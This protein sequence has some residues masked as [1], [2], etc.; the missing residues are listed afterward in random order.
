MKKILKIY[1]SIILFLFIFLVLLILANVILKINIDRSKIQKQ[2]S[3]LQQISEQNAMEDRFLNFK[4]TL[5]SMDIVLDNIIV[6]DK[7]IDFQVNKDMNQQQMINLINVFETTNYLKIN[8]IS[9]V[10]NNF[11][12]KLSVSAEI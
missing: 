9:I 1:K 6:N 3:L 12:Y 2:E 10:K 11:D 7:N 5:L 4:N 8:S